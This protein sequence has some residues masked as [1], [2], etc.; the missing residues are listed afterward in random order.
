MSH[1]FSAEFPIVWVNNPKTNVLE[2]LDP[3]QDYNLITS[4]A[5]KCTLILIPIHPDK[6][7]EMFSG[8]ENAQALIYFGLTTRF[9]S[10]ADPEVIAAD[11]NLN[12]VYSWELPTETPPAINLPPSSEAGYYSLTIENRQ[13]VIFLP[14]NTAVWT[15]NPNLQFHPIVPYSPIP[16]Q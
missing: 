7:T 11:N 15:Y 6:N 8:E 9:T 4:P 5:V 12:A 1:A 13:I 2:I 14:E 3:N 10:Q 16:E